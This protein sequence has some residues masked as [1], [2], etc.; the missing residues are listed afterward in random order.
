MD[1][2]VGASCGPPHQWQGLCPHPG[3]VAKADLA[4]A[5]RN[6]GSSSHRALCLHP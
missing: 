2:P 3:E 6:E 5:Y 4:T 1:P